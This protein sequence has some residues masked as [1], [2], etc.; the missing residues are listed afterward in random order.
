M[1]FQ[2]TA[3]DYDGTAAFSDRGRPPFGAGGDRIR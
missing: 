3:D 1:D 2:P